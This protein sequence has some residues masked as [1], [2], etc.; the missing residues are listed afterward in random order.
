MIRLAL[1]LLSLALAARATVVAPGMLLLDGA[2]VGRDLVVVGERGSILVSSDNGLTWQAATVP[3]L[4][5]L[6]GVSFAP[7]TPRGWAV[8]H[9]ALI[10]TTA[11]A[12]RTWTKQWGGENLSDS[13]LDV[14]ALDARHV[15]AVGAYGLYL[16][17]TDG[18]QTWTRRKLNDDDH[19]LNRLSLGPTGTL[20]LAGEHGT[21]LRSTDNG[22]KWAR[23]ES[24]YDGSF[25]GILPLDKRTLFAH[26]LRGRLFRSIDDGN[27]WE[28]V[29]NSLS[30]L[31]ATA[32]KLRS[33]FIVLAGQARALLVSR[34]YGKT[35]DLWPAPLSAG[36]A[37][38]LET[39]DGSIL[40]LGESG[41]TLLPK[42]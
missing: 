15:I 14:L 16:T 41:A 7:G 19:H 10:L 36:V 29:P 35:V 20:Y 28:P 13:F 12:G 5:T 4:A 39:P 11:D 2:V 22:A 24:P 42:P 38:L 6:T 1:F 30:V 37:E 3:T 32:L 21:L 40:A 31:F 33:N 9:D 17:S 27:N 34:D 26:G 18:G 8:G 25:Y 23:L